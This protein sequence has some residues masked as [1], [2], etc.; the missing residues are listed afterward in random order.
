MCVYLCVSLSVYVSAHPSLPPSLR[1]CLFA[2]VCLCVFVRI[3][4]APLSVAPPVY[5]CGTSIICVT[6]VCDMMCCD[7]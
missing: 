5:M 4:V 6:Y 1:V 3:Y 7:G 2:Y